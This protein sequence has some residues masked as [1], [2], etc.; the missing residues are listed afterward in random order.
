MRNEQNEVIHNDEAL[1]EAFVRY[2]LKTEPRDTEGGDQRVTIEATEG[3]M[4]KKSKEGNQDHEEHI[5]S[6]PGRDIMEIT[7]DDSQNEPRQK[8]RGVAL[9][10]DVERGLGGKR[11]PPFLLVFFF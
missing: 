7:Q 6:W 9:V 8:N 10:A 3:E 4:A 2:N 5:D 1:K 11:T